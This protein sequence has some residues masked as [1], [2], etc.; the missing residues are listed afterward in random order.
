MLEVELLYGMHTS[1]DVN[2]RNVPKVRAQLLGMHSCGHQ[3]EFELSAA[4]TEVAEND[5]KELSE[6][7][8]FMGLVYEDVGEFLEGVVSEEFAEEDSRRHEEQLGSCGVF[9]LE[10][11]VIADLGIR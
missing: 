6:A 3:D 11:D 1:T 5:E 2:L 10:A 9:A 8:A 4:G 7:V